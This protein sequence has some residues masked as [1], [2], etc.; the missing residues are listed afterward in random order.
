MA[1]ELKSLV[2]KVEASAQPQGAKHIWSPMTAIFPTFTKKII[3]PAT[4][5]DKEGKSKGNIGAVVSGMPSV[6]ARANLFK[7]ALDNVIDPKIQTSGLLLFYGSLIDEW[8]GLIAS[9]AL[10]YNDIQIRRIHL[11]YSD[12]KTINDTENIYEP[13]G[14]F[15]NVLFERKPL[16]CD[17]SAPINSLKTPFI[18][19]ILYK[20]KVIGGTSPDSFLFTSV[21]YTITEEE[22]PFINKQ[23]K[24]FTDPLHSDISPKELKELHSYVKHINN[25]VEKF[26][27]NF[28][29]VE[30]ILKPNYSNING[31]LQ[32][33]LTEIEKYALEK[34][35]SI[36]EQIPEV[37]CFQAPFSLLFN[38]STE[39][40]G[41]E[42]I[43]YT[44]PETGRIVFD[45]KDLLLE[46]QKC[47]IANI[48]CGE[49][50]NSYLVD[51]ALYLLKAEV[52]EEYGMHSYFS[53]PL[54]P[55]GLNVFGKNLGSLLGIENSDVRSRI[56]AEY[57]PNSE[58]VKV[59]LKLLTQTN[60]E[61]SKTQNYKVAK[62]VIQY[63]DI[64]IWPNFISKQ[65]NKYEMYSE[66]PHN[67]P[68]W[69]AKP[70]V[71]DTED[72]Y[73]RI[74]TD[75]K[76][77]PVYLASDGK[78]TDESL[79]SLKISYNNTVADVPY[80]YEIY[81][82]T[83]PYKGL[84]FSFQGKDGGFAVIKYGNLEGEG[85]RNRMNDTIS[86]KEAALGIDFGS[87]NTSVA[88]YSITDQQIQK[89]FQFKNR[90]ISLLRNDV[91]NNDERH[92]VE[93][94]IFFFQ[95]DEIEG[96]AI[97]SVIT[98]HDSKRI[99]K[100]K[101]LQTTASLLSESI[102]G[103]FP[104]FEKNLPIE[105]G[106]DNR[107]F[108]NYA[109]VQDA[110][111]GVGKV[112]IV[113]NMKWSS[114][115]IEN[116]HKKAYLSALLLH[117]YAQ[118]FEENHFPKTLKWSYPSSM[119]QSLISEYN[120]IWSTLNTVNPLIRNNYELEVFTNSG[121]KYKQLEDVFQSGVQSSNAGWGSNDIAMSNWDTASGW[122]AE[123]G[124]K[125]IN[126]WGIEEDKS[127][128]IQ[129]IS[130]SQEPFKFDF[131]QLD[132]SAA[133]T[134]ACAVANYLANTNAIENDKNNLTLCFD[135]GGST[136]DISALCQMMGKNGPGLA[137]V[138]QS[139]I[140]FAAQRVS[141][142]TKYSKNF[143]SVLVTMLERKGITI[144]GINKGENKYNSSTAPYYFEQLVDRLEGDEFKE[145]YKLLEA[146]CK[147]L[148]CV[149]LYVTGLIMYY[150]GQL[151]YKLKKEID[152][153]PDK[154]PGMENWAP[155][156]NIVF[157]G[158]GARIFD[159][160]EAINPQASQQ[161]Y[162]NQ[163]IKGF[164][165]IQK[166][167][168][169]LSGPPNIN[170]LSELGDLKYEVSKGLSYPTQRL[171]VPENNTAIELIGE[172]NFQLL[173]KDG[174]W[175]DLAFDTSVNGL[176]FRNIESYFISAPQDENK[177]CP[178]FMEF[179]NE[180]YNVTTQFFQLPLSK[181][182]CMDG[183]RKMNIC[184]YIKNLPEFRQ[185]Q[186]NKT[187]DD[188]FDFSAPVIILE[189]MKFL[190]EVVLKKMN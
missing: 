47:E 136:T 71:M 41:S 124:S 72:E 93:N 32:S 75:D 112:E 170:P 161:Y 171:Y 73:F 126:G 179:A 113:H 35:I 165:G 148:I 59:T 143:R 100:E 51:R 25:N 44:E 108:L 79:A 94:E 128:G 27:K 129:E 65:W 114:H 52:K 18:D 142:A 119:S 26:R 138:K 40:Y 187:D 188:S 96:N 7:N 55:L 146:N 176:M 174:K 29:S 4:G 149:N 157:T 127:S 166:A 24:K 84:K 14:A 109:P 38:F 80:K 36:E 11:S 110:E 53:L 69:Q 63:K 107:Y 31:N 141:Q 88:Y 85:I 177:P 17:Q 87:T 70:M 189:G 91:K 76:G 57:D 122:E 8:R 67:S 116:S 137:M 33:W 28:D 5:E 184:S 160:F 154:V 169:H 66:L 13:K 120:Q 86:L 163:F 101:A 61:I 60:R 89:S 111:I 90:R 150:A 105:E 145:F 37:S 99:H 78:I 123:E 3:T 186:D 103:G 42:G 20:G 147:E 115:E 56:Y 125:P 19:I 139:S 178:R 39:L 46:P 155:K 106:T 183:F 43:I 23:T 135:I 167:Q 144:Q 181:A 54:S 132:G 156:I 6:F 117:I 49:N 121:I 168:E 68:N 130:I 58:I 173:Q 30:E 97:K 64:L 164:G 182:D 118:L 152:A 50:T 185:A 151:S 140:R 16:W 81:E 9:V 131:V 134:E 159:W 175:V 12:G 153:S 104:C 102:K 82:S 10:N 190:E 74:L 162:L 158:K 92:A 133:L 34:G 62:K 21:S 15:G 95:N 98:L 77:E 172:E 1:E 180:F 22:K 83:K 48:D 45:P 2:I